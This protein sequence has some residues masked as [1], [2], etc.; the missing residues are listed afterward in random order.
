MWRTH[1]R[2][3]SQREFLQFALIK[4]PYSYIITLF[5]WHNP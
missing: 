3:F 1:E 5:P 2:G 4:V